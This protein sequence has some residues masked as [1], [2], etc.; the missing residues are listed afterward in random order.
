MEVSMKDEMMGN[1][2]FPL[3]EGESGKK[4]KK[5]EKIFS[6]SIRRSIRTLLR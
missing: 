3:R 5:K 6:W 4:E 2:D 1:N